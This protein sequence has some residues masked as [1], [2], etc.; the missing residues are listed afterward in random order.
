M[1][2]TT[3][4]FARRCRHCGS[5][6]SATS[7]FC[8]KC[9]ATA[10]VLGD[11]TDPI[12]DQVVRLFGADLDIERELGRGGMAVVF[13]A[14][15]PALQR[16]VAVKVLLPEIANDH[17]MA[18]RFLRE[19]R[20]VASL[21]HPHVVT[22]Y[23]VR[24]RDGVHTI[25]MQ[26]VE[27][28]SLDAILLEQG[29][30]P[31]QVAGMLLAQSAEGLQHAHDRGVIHRDVKPSNVL[32]DRD[33][34]AIV[35]DFGI[36]RRDHGPRTTETGI[37]IGT[38]AYMSPEQRIADPLT[39]ATDQYA[40]GVMAFE[41]LAGRLPFM[42]TPGQTMRAHMHDPPPS[43]RELRPDVSPAVEAAVNRMLAKQVADRFPSLKDAERA[44]RSLVPDGGQA[45]LE[46][47]AYSHV[48]PRVGSQVVAA[49]ARPQSTVRPSAPIVRTVSTPAAAPGATRPAAPSGNRG[50]IMAGTAA[51]VAILALGYV[52]TSGVGPATSPGASSAPPV[53]AVDAP[54]AGRGDET[55]GSGGEQL[56]GTE[57]PVT[58]AS[59]SGDAGRDPATPRP[60]AAGSTANPGSATSTSADRNAVG[61]VTAVPLAAPTRD[62]TQRTIVPTAPVVLPPGNPVVSPPAGPPERAAAT[63]SLPA[64]T[65]AD[66]RRIAREFVTMLNQRRFRELGQL[67]K[68]GGDDESRA[69]LLRLTESAPDFAAGFDR[70]ATAPAEW[71]K[72]FETVVYLDLQWRGGAQVIRVRLYCAPDGNGWKLVGLA[73]YPAG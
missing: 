15:D 31:V 73:A 25:V 38:W 40:L 58:P 72:G 28:R 42:G 55:A 54:V 11:G 41:L 29:Q 2:E 35:S 45:T 7:S 12:R 14:F 4:E 57:P 20:T 69:E 46:L 70:V 30:L 23:S 10:E 62:S 61:A 49:A 18:D 13:A 36:A 44:F 47:A 17:G 22:V 21:Q 52:L 56:A 67:E 16:R 9:G 8:S 43:L 24:S 33:G 3:V 6:L 5:V 39:P 19:A 60:A 51:G 68:I 1:A 37:V 53:G 64:A 59:Q 26:F 27:G 65:V 50:R 71:T 32:I 34:R 48:R 66:A 63:P